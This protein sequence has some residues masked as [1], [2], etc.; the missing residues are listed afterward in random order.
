[1]SAASWL[2]VKD[3][4]IYYNRA[5]QS[6]ISRSLRN[7]V[8][9]VAPTSCRTLQYMPRIPEHSGEEVCMFFDKA[10]KSKALYNV[11]LSRCIG[12]CLLL[13]SR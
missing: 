5:T 4:T 1:M 3:G 13:Y 7:S 6:T 2:S 9:I 8:H 10:V 11:T 12:K